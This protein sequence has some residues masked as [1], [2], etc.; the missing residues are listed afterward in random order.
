MIARLTFILLAALIA[1]AL[2][3][4]TAQHKARKLYV[5]LQKEQT[6]AKRLDEEW[7]QLQL[8]QGTWATHGRIERIATRELNM[9]L[10]VAARIEVVP[11][12]KESR[13]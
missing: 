11:A 7:G 3:V 2:A 4:V 1:C 6:A 13:P 5:E 8:E 9:R 10:P 12:P